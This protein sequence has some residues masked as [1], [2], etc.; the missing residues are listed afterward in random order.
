MVHVV[1][2]SAVNNNGKGDLWKGWSFLALSFSADFFHSDA[3]SRFSLKVRNSYKMCYKG[4]YFVWM[5]ERT[6]VMLM[7]VQTYS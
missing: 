1:G 7:D 2:E 5:D 3:C 4:G 6:A